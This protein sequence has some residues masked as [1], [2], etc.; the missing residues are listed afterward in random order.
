MADP[1][2][3]HTATLLNDGTVLIAG[4][5]NSN[6]ISAAELFD[7]TTGTFTST[8]A[9]TA[10]RAAHAATL[11]GNATVLVTGGRNENGTSQSTSDLYQ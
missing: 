7:P 2:Q 9:M 3:L 11:L 10:V 4:G 1:R 6:T 5:L 8:G